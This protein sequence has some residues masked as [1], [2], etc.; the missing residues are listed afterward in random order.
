L[1]VF[2]E[3]E[4]VSVV[5]K[6]KHFKKPDRASRQFRFTIIFSVTQSLSSILIDK[7]DMM[8]LARSLHLM[9]SLLL[10]LPSFSHCVLTDVVVQDRYD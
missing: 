9:L 1:N 8:N 5:V 2:E 6:K 10:M 3:E 7:I 4:E